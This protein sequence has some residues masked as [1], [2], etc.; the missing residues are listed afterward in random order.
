MTTNNP[1]DDYTPDQRIIKSYVWHGNNCFFVST[2]ERDSSAMLGPRRFNE[3]IVWAFDWEKN[4]SGELIST[5]GGS[6]GSIFT[7]LQVCQFLHDT[8]RPEIPEDEL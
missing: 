6:R 5:L 2:I 4:E 7:H 8:G 1:H 3:T